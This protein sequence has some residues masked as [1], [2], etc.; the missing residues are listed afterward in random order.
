MILTDCNPARVILMGCDAKVE[1]VHELE[2][3]DSL[4]GNIP[5]LGGGGGTSFRPPFDWLVE[6]GI[7]PETLVYF[8]DMYGDFPEDPGYPVIWCSSTADKEAPFGDTIHVEV[9]NG[10]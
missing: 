8:T 1:K 10:Q 5:P 4:Q 7:R 6:Q 3:G 9:G 2:M